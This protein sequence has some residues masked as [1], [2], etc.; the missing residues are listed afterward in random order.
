MTSQTT[1][2]IFK[3]TF[4]NENIQFSIKISLKFPKGPINNIPALLQ[5]MAWRRPGDKALSEPLTQ[6]CGNRGRWVNS[7]IP[8]AAY[9]RLWTG[10][11]LVQ[12]TSCRLFGDKPLSKP[13]L[14]YYQLDP[15]KQTS[16]KFLSKIKLFQENA[17]E[18][19]VCEMAAILSRGV[20]DEVNIRWPPCEAFGNP[21]KQHTEHKLFCNITGNDL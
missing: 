16:V 1:D 19:F 15:L 5:I 3:C 18:S 17:F 7:S 10:S 12:I 4:L 2:D 20:G 21:R 11:A 9:M 14:G 6:I 8:S 13:M